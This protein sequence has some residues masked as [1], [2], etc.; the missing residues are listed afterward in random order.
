MKN[1]VI[2]FLKTEDGAITV[3][4]VAL[5]AGIVAMGVVAYTAV[6]DDSVGLANNIGSYMVDEERLP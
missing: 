5:T 3:D 2:R 4:W 6:K 1:N